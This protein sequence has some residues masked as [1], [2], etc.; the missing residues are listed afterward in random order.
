MASRYHVMLLPG[1]G[2][3]PEI[4]A[5]AQTVIAAAGERFGIIRFG[6]RA[7]VYLPDGV[8]PLVTV[9]QSMVGGET[10]IA[11]LDGHEPARVGSVR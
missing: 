9:G 5:C 3:G 1:D 4:V 11:D 10:V 6:S 2:V 8:T 7:D